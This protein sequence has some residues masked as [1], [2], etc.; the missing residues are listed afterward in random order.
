MLCFDL[1]FDRT[2]R[3]TV[4]LVDAGVH[5]REFVDAYFFLI[6]VG[7]H[8]TPNFCDGFCFAFNDDELT[9]DDAET[10]HGVRVKTRFSGS[11]IFRI[12][13]VDFE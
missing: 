8:G 13:A 1:F 4:A 5:P 11:L 12:G 9:G 2:D 6:P 3:D 10:L 7:G